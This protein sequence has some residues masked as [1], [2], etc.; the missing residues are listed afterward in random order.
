MS[1]N[2][3]KIME[4]IEQKL[5]PFAEKIGGNKHLMAIRD[6]FISAM[7]F[8]IVGSFLLIFAYPPF[9]EDTT[10]SFGKAWIEFS[11]KYG[12][13]ILLPFNMTMGVMAIFVTVSTA[14]SL[15]EAYN[16]DRL[17]GVL[18][19]LMG[20]LLISAPAQNG[21]L[22]TNFLGAKGLFGG[23]VMALFS[24]EVFK[25]CKD[26]KLTIKLPNG[27]P[28]RIAKSFELLIPVLLLIMIVYPLSLLSQNLYGKLIPELIMTLVSPL[29][30][31]TDSLPGMLFIIFLANILWFMGIHVSVVTGILN[32]F[33]FA[34]AALNQDALVAGEKMTKIFTE[35]FWSAYIT[36]GGAGATLSLTIL[37]L[38][39]KAKHLKTIGKL[40]IIPS[41]FNIN[42][43]VLF[44]APL[45]M[46]P[47]FFIP[48]VFIPMINATIAYFLTKLEI[49]PI[50]YSLPPWTVP[51]PILGMWAAGWNFRAFFL[52]IFLMFISGIIWY[53]FMKVYEKQLL[54][55]EEN[56][57]QE[58]VSFDDL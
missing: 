38:F 17:T 19:T 23:I 47:L 3:K 25:F 14:Y 42:E 34:N 15:L 2:S 35:P 10:F 48:L 8:L 44:G 40:S 58:E 13:K 27:V 24:V 7:P 4:L 18:L 46:N 28:P 22:G 52:V 57:E 39:S 41:I 45:T 12:D 43:P 50:L 26:K 20:F 30:K 9:A 54:A 31:V 16:L 33:L 49:V 56:E 36:I 29:V 32:V 21:Q 37:F 51:A 53:P 6:G 5:S 55:Q 1:T 11:M